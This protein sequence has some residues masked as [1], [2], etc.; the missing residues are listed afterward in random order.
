[1]NVENMD[2]LTM[3]SLKALCD[4]IFELESGRS[5]EGAHAFERIPPSWQR[6]Y[7][8]NLVHKNCEV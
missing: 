3:Q 1:M 5:W 6:D 8:R 7:V 2:H 4:S